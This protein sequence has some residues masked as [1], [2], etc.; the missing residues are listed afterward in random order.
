MNRVVVVIPTYRNE[1]SEW[2][3]LSLEQCVKVLSKNH[4]IKI[5]A[6]E[7]IDS[8]GLQ[9]ERFDSKFFDGLAGYNKLML[10]AEF[11][12]RFCDYDY[13]LIYQL[14][15]WVFRDRFNE[16]CSQGWDY[17]GAPWLIKGTGCAPLSILARNILLKLKCYHTDLFRFRMVGNGGVSLRKVETFRQKTRNIKQIPRHGKLNEDIYWS[18]VAGL[19]IPDW[20]TA[21]HFSLDEVPYPA[22]CNIAPDFC[23]GFSKSQKTLQYW[24]KLKNL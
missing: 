2:E 3:K 24:E 20:R 16:W 13:I 19:K 6:P 7:G 10:A 12:D 23:H 22:E 15:A 5:V 18:L 21:Q 14:D 17:I 9:V 4:D 8:H 1:L 11:Y